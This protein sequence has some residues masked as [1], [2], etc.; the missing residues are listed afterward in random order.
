MEGLDGAQ[1]ASTQPAQAQCAMHRQQLL[2]HYLL[3]SRASPLTLLMI[4]AQQVQHAVHQQH[5][6]LIQQGVSSLCSLPSC[7]VHRDDHVAQHI[8]RQL[9]GSTQGAG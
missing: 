7:G 6:G 8:H 9:Q 4:V 3:V 1:E 5:A 2:Q